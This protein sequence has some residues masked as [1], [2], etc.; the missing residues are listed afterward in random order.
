[1]KTQISMI[2]RALENAMSY[3]EYRELIDALLAAGKTTGSNHSE[4]ML[5]YTEL[6]KSRMNK[7]DKHYNVSTDVQHLL[8]SWEKT[9]I[10]LLITEAWCGDAAHAAP[11]MAQMADQ[12]PAIELKLVLRDENSELM[13]QFLTNGARSIPKLIR[14][15]AE[16]LEILGTWGSRPEELTELFDQLKL[17]EPD[18]QERKKALQVWYAR[19]KGKAIEQELAAMLAGE[20]VN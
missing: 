19:N 2:S 5:R 11:V 8:K 15:K 1:M 4:D 13:D 14:L 20:M 12:S 18:P 7:W 17:S 6:N 3:A 16:T 9:E 10:W